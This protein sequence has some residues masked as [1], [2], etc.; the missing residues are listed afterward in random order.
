MVNNMNKIDQI[1]WGNKERIRRA[2]EMRKK[3]KK[4]GGEI[5]YARWR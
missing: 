4:K 3:N 5:K 1:Y 2:E